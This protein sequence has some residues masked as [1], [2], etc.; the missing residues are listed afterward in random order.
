MANKIVDNI[1]NSIELI[2]DPWIDSEIHDFFHLDENVVEFSYE[3]ID[4][5]YYIEVMLKQ[6]DIHTI[7]MHFMS[8]VS[9]MQHSNFTFYSRKANDQIISY[10]LISGG[11]DMKG[12]YCEVNYEHI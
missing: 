9:L 4:N 11:S 1:I 5:K 12:F 8:F 6:P 3:V 2:T 10:R 7:K